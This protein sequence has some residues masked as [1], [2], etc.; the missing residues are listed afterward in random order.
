MLRTVLALLILSLISASVIVAPAYSL[1]ISESGPLTSYLKKAEPFL[2]GSDQVIN[3][4]GFPVDRSLITHD[5]GGVLELGEMQYNGNPS[6]T[7]VYG[8]GNVAGLSKNGH[9]IGFG[10]A[11]QSLLGISVS[12]S[13][14]PSS[15]GFSY[16][17][18]S[19]VQFDQLPPA[20]NPSTPDIAGRLS[21]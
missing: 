15:L 11:G 21:G 18:D 4:N 12:Q 8:S 7:L 2:Q 10:G 3:V 19:P 17:A 1:S 14:P 13:P 9:F 5:F 20:G 6:R 16:A